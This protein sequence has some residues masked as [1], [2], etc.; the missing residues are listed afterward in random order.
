[1]PGF[2]SPGAFGGLGGWEAIPTPDPPL[3]A[4]KS[5]SKNK[6]GCSCCFPCCENCGV[7]GFDAGSD[8]PKY[9]KVLVD[10]TY[11][12]LKARNPSATDTVEPGSCRWYKSFSTPITVGSCTD[13]SRIQL[14][15]SPDFTL[16]LLDAA[17][18]VL[19]LWFRDQTATGASCV[20]AYRPHWLAWSSGCSLSDNVLIEPRQHKESCYTT[21]GTGPFGTGVDT[22]SGPCAISGTDARVPYYV[23]VWFDKPN[24]GC[25]GLDPDYICEWSFNAGNDR[26][27]SDEGVTPVAGNVY[28][29]RFGYYCTVADYV[30]VLTQLVK[31]DGT[32][33]VANFLADVPRVGFIGAKTYSMPLFNQ[34]NGGVT[35]CTISGLV[36]N[37]CPA[38]NLTT[39]V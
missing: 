25:I 1:M 15:I 26:I 9:W 21:F 28:Y 3:T 23:R 7:E 29:I 33:I 8:T 31:T 10:G 14:N 16:S 37:V 5:F 4:P 12:N 11:H 38:T 20:N 6:P 39:P 24:T 32:T 36:A 13:V 19:G 34:P 35:G 27:Y 30:R 2:T 18:A 22:V 17:G